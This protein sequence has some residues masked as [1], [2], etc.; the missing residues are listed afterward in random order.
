MLVGHS[1]GSRAVLL[2]LDQFKHHVR[3]VFLVA[4]FANWVEN[5]SRREGVAY[6]DFFE[7]KIDVEELKKLSDTF[8]AVHSLDDDHIDFQQGEEIAH[9]LGAKLV[10]LEDRL[11]MSSPDNAPVIL[12]ILREALQF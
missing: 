10:T 1:L 11:H 7:Y 5:A 3:A 9:D 4:P 6:P 2:Y 12:Q 8:V